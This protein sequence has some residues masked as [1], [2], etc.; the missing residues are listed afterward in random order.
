MSIPVTCPECRYP[1]V[2]CSSCTE[3]RCNC[4][5]AFVGMFQHWKD[6]KPRDYERQKNE[7]LF[8]HREVKAW[9]PR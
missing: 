8:T 7:L 1:L 2:P 9:S 3:F 6:G 5:G 4:I